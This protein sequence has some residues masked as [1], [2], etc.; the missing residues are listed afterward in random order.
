MYDGSM[1]DLLEHAVATARG[2]PP[3]MQDDIARLML[4]YA[5]IE[6][7]VVQ[8]TPE[9]EDSLARSRAQAARGEFASD[10]DVAAV[11][12]KYRR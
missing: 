10:E 2:L 6:Q 1:T 3:D 4:L 5:G 11:W 8:L 12:A 9:E 7:P